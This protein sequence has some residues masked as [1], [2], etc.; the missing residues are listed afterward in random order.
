ML[1]IFQKCHNFK[2][3]IIHNQNV[4]ILKICFLFYF[5]SMQTVRFNE[6]YISTIDTLSINDG[7]NVKI[8]RLLLIV[9]HFLMYVIF[10]FK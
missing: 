7:I 10:M 4:T 3:E 1:N 2:C 9:L 6:N 5:I 8:G